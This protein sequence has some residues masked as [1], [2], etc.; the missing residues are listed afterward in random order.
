MK[1]TNKLQYPDLA[2]V[3]FIQVIVAHLSNESGVRLPA[4]DRRAQPRT[5]TG[6]FCLAQSQIWKRCDV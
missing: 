1:K 6:F 2:Q 5:G 3:N 4:I